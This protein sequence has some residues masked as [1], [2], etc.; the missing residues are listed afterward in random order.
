MSLLSPVSVHRS[1]GIYIAAGNIVDVPITIQEPSMMSYKICVVDP[2]QIPPSQQPGNQGQAQ[3]PTSPTQ[4]ATKQPPPQP[5]EGMDVSIGI[6][7]IKPNV[8][9]YA[10]MAAQIGLGVEDSDDEIVDPF[11]ILVQPHRINQEEGALFVPNAG[12]FFLRLDNTY[13]W[14]T[15]KTVWYEV[16]LA[17]RKVVYAKQANESD[18]GHVLGSSPASP[19]FSSASPQSPVQHKAGEETRRMIEKARE[20]QEKAIRVQQ[21][22]LKLNKEK[23]TIIRELD[24]RHEKQ[25]QLNST[26]KTLV[27]EI[28]G[29]QTKIA[30][31]EAVASRQ[32]RQVAKLTAKVIQTKQDLAQAENE[33]QDSAGIDKKEKKVRFRVVGD[34]VRDQTKVIG[35]GWKHVTSMLGPEGGKVNLNYDALLE[36]VH[37]KGHSDQQAES[38]QEDEP[39]LSSADNDDEDAA[40]MSPAQSSPALSNPTAK[41]ATPPAQPQAQV[42]SSPPSSAPSVSAPQSPTPSIPTPT[43]AATTTTTTASSSPPTTSPAAPFNP[44]LDESIEMVMIQT[45]VDRPRAIHALKENGG[46]VINTIMALATIE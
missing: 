43:V 31:L 38:G 24:S 6:M 36:I 46:D 28:T 22:L 9:P 41:P 5:M 2:K 32:E 39:K 45:G 20:E 27:Q 16:L 15:D 14:L 10:T 8:D 30:N 17:P 18:S 7:G 37:H 29:T 4:S 13:S 33:R 12:Q 1:N 3:Q 44:N 21:R 34:M 42:S 11:E 26:L 25:N 40:P 35:S 19:T 23:D